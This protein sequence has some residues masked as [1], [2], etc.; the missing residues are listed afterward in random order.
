MSLQYTNE[1]DAQDREKLND[2][3]QQL[4]IFYSFN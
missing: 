1:R 4:I 2:L 3:Q